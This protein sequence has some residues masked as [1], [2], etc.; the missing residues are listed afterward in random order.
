MTLTAEEK[1]FLEN[2]LAQM[3]GTTQYYQHWTKLLKHTDGVQFLAEYAKAYWLIDLVASYQT[4]ANIRQVPFQLWELKVLDSKGVVTM[5]EDT[6][7]PVLVKQ[8]IE[9][10]DFPLSEIKLYVENGVLLLPS[11]H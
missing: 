8:V 4:K 5:R 11:E 1:E 2:G 9:Y 3:I 10:T 6:N 7:A